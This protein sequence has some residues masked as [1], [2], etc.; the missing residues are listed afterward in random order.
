LGTLEIAKFATEIVPKAC[1]T[2]KG[3]GGLAEGTERH[4]CMWWKRWTPAHTAEHQ[5]R[6]SG[7]LDLQEPTVQ[8]GKDGTETVQRL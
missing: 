7:S 4:Y 6:L 2:S 8:E 3:R 5:V 1:R